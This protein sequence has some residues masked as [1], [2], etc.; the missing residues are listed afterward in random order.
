M[1]LATV[2][3]NGRPQNRIVL[4]KGYDPRGLRFF[5]S[6]KSAK[7]RELDK[8]PYAALGFFWPALQR[9]VRVMGQAERLP[10]EESV[11]Y[12]ASRPYDSQLGAWASPQSQ[13]VRDRAE[14]DS[15][16][17]EMATRFQ[18]KEVEC[19]EFWGGFV[20][21]PG[22]LGVLARPAR[23]PARPLPLPP[24]WRRRRLGHRAARPPEIS[25]A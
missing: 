7:A 20:V 5:T 23:P 3:E 4:L 13:P 22:E 19:P 15:R 9:Q 24:P 25:G 14:L 16:W 2:G 6:Y 18:G 11:E 17:E 1:S 10:R 21:S 8:F 12:F